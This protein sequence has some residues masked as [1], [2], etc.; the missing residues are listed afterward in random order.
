MPSR[1]PLWT[2][3]ET[4]CEPSPGPCSLSSD[5]MSLIARCVL[6]KHM[7][8]DDKCTLSV[9]GE[10]SETPGALS[11]VLIPTLASQEDLA[12]KEFC[13]NCIRWQQPKGLPGCPCSCSAFFKWGGGYLLVPLLGSGDTLFLF[14]S[15]MLRKVTTR[16]WLS[17]INAQGEV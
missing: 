5:F 1:E 11:S 8:S 9:T 10:P 6:L 13:P 17:G 16:E 2:L 15:W 3:S 4:V 12:N 7:T 14:S